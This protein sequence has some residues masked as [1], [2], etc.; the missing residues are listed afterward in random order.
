MKFNL[1]R[2]DSLDSIKNCS[3]FSKQNNNSFDDIQ[4]TIIQN[5]LIENIN[6]IDNNHLKINDSYNNNQVHKNQNNGS[7]GTGFFETSKQNNFN[8]RQTNLLSL[9]FNNFPLE[10]INEIK[11]NNVEKTINNINNNNNPLFNSMSKNT[12]LDIDNHTNINYLNNFFNNE[13]SRIMN[14]DRNEILNINQIPNQINNNYCSIIN[15]ELVKS[16][17]LSNLGYF[18]FSTYEMKIN[19][20]N[21][22]NSFSN[23]L[24]TY[25]C[26]KDNSHMNNQIGQ[27]FLIN[28]LD[29]QYI[30]QNY[31]HDHQI[32]EQNNY[33]STNN[34]CIENNNFLLLKNL[35]NQSDV[36]QNIN[37][38]DNQSYKTNSNDIDN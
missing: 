29:N 35:Y 12:N 25:N 30:K 38:I 22:L 28:N 6:K 9:D 8:N 18:D 20:L 37:I 11:N 15:E 23:N 16:S 2:N 24:N 17:N 26:I 3:L 7:F 31:I 32:N 14:L 4:K 33:P 1:N 27:N 21:T 13:K 19:L 34:N 5:P 36:Q 10:L